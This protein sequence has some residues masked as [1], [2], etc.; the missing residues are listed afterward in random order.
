LLPRQPRLRCQRQPMP[1][2]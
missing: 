2:A 1:T